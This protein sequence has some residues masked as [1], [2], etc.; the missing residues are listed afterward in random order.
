LDQLNVPEADDRRKLVALANPLAETS[1][2]MRTTLLPGLFGAVARNTSRGNDDL[3]L[4]EFGSTFFAVDGNPP[5]PIP[6][7]EHRPSAV[8]LA[9]IEAAIPAQPKH[10]AAVLSGSWHR[11]GWQGDA[12]PADWKQAFAFADAVATAVGAKITRE[13]AEY[14]PWHPGRCAALRVAGEI[15]GHAGELH[16]EVISAYGLPARSAA[17]ELD[18]DALTRL[19][20]AS[21]S[22]AT[23]SSHP[24]AK[25][26][27]ALVVAEDIAVG[28]VE[29]CLIAGA[30]D[31]LE[32]I[33]LF[34]IFT[35]GN[36]PEGKKSVAFALRF[37]AT[38][39]TLTETETAAA[40]DAAVAEATK[41]LGA[42]LRAF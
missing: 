42:E 30:G 23:I 33:S 24:V 6:S 29:A 7:V 25:E 38:D 41:L 10:I 32:S 3:A 14:A 36:V 4:F 19:A 13:S 1:P 8:E 31:L 9:E 16:P 22:I 2:Y 28:D 20:P 5:A 39:R 15:I 34:D 26:D 40:R 12:E 27:V 21:G 11:A 18:L 37:R 35:G 17:V